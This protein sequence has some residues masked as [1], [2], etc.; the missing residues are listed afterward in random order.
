MEETR[1]SGSSGTSTEAAIGAASR[2]GIEA[3]AAALDWSEMEGQT[4]AVT[5]YESVVLNRLD[6]ISVTL[7]FICGLLF[8]LLIFG[9]MVSKKG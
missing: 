1:N 2:T 3:G 6:T 4:I 5:E 8:F 9:A 7:A